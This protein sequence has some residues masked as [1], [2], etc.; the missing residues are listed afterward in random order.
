MK[1]FILL[2]AALLL[3]TM[4]TASADGVVTA[5]NWDD[6]RDLPDNM[7]KIEEDA[8]RDDFTLTSIVIP[9]G[10]QSIGA[11]AFAGC[12]SL[13]KIAVL[14]PDV[15]LGTNA[16][17]TA[18]ENKV[19]WGYKD[20]TAEAY[21]AAYGYTFKRIYLISEKE[22]D[23]KQAVLDYADTLVRAK[24][25][26]GTLDCITFARHCYLSA[27]WEGSKLNVVIPDSCPRMYN[28]PAQREATKYEYVRID[29]VSDLQPGDIICWTDDKYWNKAKDPNAKEPDDPEYMKCSHVG[30]YVAD[31][32]DT[33]AYDAEHGITGRPG[34]KVLSGRTATLYY[35]INASKVFVESSSSAGGVR[36]NYFTDYYVRNF[37]C[38]WRIL[39]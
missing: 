34:N 4:M 18:D 14:N 35:N 9:E 10:L 26:Y 21:A 38:A 33:K 2:T 12:A 3:L 22:A 39:L 8:F 28:L 32:F 19:I 37:L 7:V 25:P 20:S 1:K 5:E 31:R 30:M 6:F 11:N 15:V 16:L 36:Y 29:S 23:I 24:V 17:G 13:E 27:T